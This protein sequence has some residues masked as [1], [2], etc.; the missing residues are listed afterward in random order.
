MPSKQVYSSHINTVH[1]DPET[2]VLKVDYQNGKRSVYSSVP[3]HVASNVFNAVS[4]G[5]EIHANVRGQY[6][7]TYEEKS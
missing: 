2:G 1:Y 3:D 7:H 6:P 4:V 5:K